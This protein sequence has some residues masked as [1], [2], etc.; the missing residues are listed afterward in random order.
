MVVAKLLTKQNPLQ[1]RT[2]K[3][4]RAMN[5]YQILLKKKSFSVDIFMTSEPLKD[6]RQRV[7]IIKFQETDPVCFPIFTIQ[8]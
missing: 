4:L 5:E 6:L 3:D 2:M 8:Y 1:I 7:E